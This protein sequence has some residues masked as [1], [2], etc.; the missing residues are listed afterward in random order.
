MQPKEMPKPDFRFTSLA[1]MA[2]A[3]RRELA[4]AA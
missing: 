2:E 1:V 4:G 3:H